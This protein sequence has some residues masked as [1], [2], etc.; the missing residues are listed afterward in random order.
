MLD[1]WTT[2]SDENVGA[3][4]AVPAHPVG[5]AVGAVREPPWDHPVRLRLPPLRRRGIKM[6]PLISCDGTVTIN[7]L[8]EIPL[9]RRGAPTGVGWSGQKIT[10]PPPV[11]LK[12]PFAVVDR[13]PE[14]SF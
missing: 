1:L 9:L 6:L 10:L 8:P 13:Y 2:T 12:Y 4:R 14:S 5:C 3:R 11:F 7:L